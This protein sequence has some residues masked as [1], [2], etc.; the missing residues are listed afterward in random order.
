[1]R[2]A[3]VEDNLKQAEELQAFFVRY[4]KEE[5][6]ECVVQH[7][8]DAF[9]FL[10]QYRPDYDVVLLDIEMPGMDGMS[11]AK[12]LRERDADVLIVFVTNMMQ[13]AIA[14]YTVSALDY[15]VK[16]VSYFEFTNLLKKVRRILETQQERDVIIRNAGSFQRISSSQIRYVEVYRH[17]LIFH[18]NT[19]NLES[20]GNL[21]EVE[22]MVSQESFFRCNNCFLVNFR[23]VDAVE[24]EEVILGE[25]RLRISHLRKKEFMEKFTQ[26]LG[27]LR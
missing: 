18:T 23:Y 6:Y 2:V 3:V 8:S 13:Y 11:A 4:S 24:K 1:M 25:E 12:R 10:D 22:S 17:K 16:P 7:F 15:I 5:N 20:W 27:K 26:Y 9:S 14:G 19:G 21:T